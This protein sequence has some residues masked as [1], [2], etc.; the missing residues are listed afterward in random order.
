MKMRT[1][2]AAS[3]VAALSVPGIA[4]A[5]TAP[6]DGTGG[7]VATVP[8]YLELIVTQPAKGFAAF[9]TAKSYELSFDVTV[10]NTDAPTQLSVTDGDAASG[11]KRG[12]LSV[13]A[14]RLPSPL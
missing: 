2:T 13:G 6:I 9:A 8:S 7:V 10:T 5:Q 12:H 11:S 4:A 14:K 3:A 1:L